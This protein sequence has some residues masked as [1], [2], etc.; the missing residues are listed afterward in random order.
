MIVTVYNYFMQNLE[1]MI[2][3]V[4]IMMST[5]I[6]FMGMLKP[7]LF[8]KV[9]NKDLRGMLLFFTSIALSFAS[10]AVTFLIKQYDFTYYWICGV[11]YSGGVIVMYAIYE[12]TP[13]RPSIHSIGSFVVEKLFGVIA[14]KVNIVAN[15]TKAIGSSID[16]VLNEFTSNKNDGKD[17]KNL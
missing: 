13:L 7:I 8:N 1:T 15:D 6:V 16:M 5:L 11:F 10:V 4:I 14:N 9:S 12:H 2:P 3:M 17:L